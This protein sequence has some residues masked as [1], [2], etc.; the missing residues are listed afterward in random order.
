ML[1]LTQVGKA[2]SSKGLELAQDKAIMSLNLQYSIQ[3]LHSIQ[4]LVSQSWQAQFLVR[5]FHS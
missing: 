1:V 3:S 2:G 5:G 4:I